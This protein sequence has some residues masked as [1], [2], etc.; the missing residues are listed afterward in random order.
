MRPVLNELNEVNA[1]AVVVTGFFFFNELAE[2]QCNLSLTC[3]L[4]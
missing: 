2:C 1:Q 4:R 3:L